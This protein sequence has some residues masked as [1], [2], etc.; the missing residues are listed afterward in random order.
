MR[1]RAPKEAEY[2]CGVLSLQSAA[3]YQLPATSNQRGRNAEMETP[4]ND[5]LKCPLSPA[6]I[7]LLQTSLDIGSTSSRPLAAM[8]SISYHTVRTEFATILL[9]MKVRTRHA[10]LM[11]AW[12]NGWIAAKAIAKS[13]TD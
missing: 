8:L 13:Q 7:T 1:R 5:P 9:L 6:L 3:S 12:R 4:T 10:A 11:I 2:D